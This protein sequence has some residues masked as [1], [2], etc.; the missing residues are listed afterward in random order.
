VII[1]FFMSEFLPLLLPDGEIEGTRGPFGYPI[2]TWDAAVEARRSSNDA[3]DGVFEAAELMLREAA[4]AIYFVDIDDPGRA[5]REGERPLF[6]GGKMMLGFNDHGGGSESR[7][8]ILLNCFPDGEDPA[9]FV[10]YS[11]PKEDGSPSNT[12]FHRADFTYLNF[13]PGKIARRNV[14]NVL[15]TCDEAVKLSREYYQF[16][17][18]GRLDIPQRLPG[19][20]AAAGFDFADT[21]YDDDMLYEYRRLERIHKEKLEPEGRYGPV[22]PS[23]QFSA[24]IKKLR[25][26]EQT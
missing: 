24:Q 11:P 15:K 23:G 14:P 2:E 20:F 1:Y 3:R 18:I 5:I 12:T 21:P 8:K 17:V 13:E 10:L 19:A 26:A 9:Q 16:Y 6:R 22:W 25:S 7:Y 4:V